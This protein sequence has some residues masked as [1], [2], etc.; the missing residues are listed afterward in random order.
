MAII[1]EHNNLISLGSDEVHIWQFSL[2]LTFMKIVELEHLLT[3]D[4]LARSHGLYG[5]LLRSRFIVG[6]GLLRRILQRYIDSKP[7]A[8]LFSY[9][10]SGKP[11]LTGHD[12]PIE[13]NL[14][15]SEGRA[16]LAIAQ[17]PVGID[18]EFV[19]VNL[20]IEGLATTVFT[21]EEIAD[22]LAVPE[23]ERYKYFFTMWVRKEA[24]MKATGHGLLESPTKFA[25]VTDAA[26]L[27]VRMTNSINADKTIPWRIYDL[28]AGLECVAA[29]AVAGT[30]SHRIMSFDLETYYFPS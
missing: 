13:F 2:D 23:Q 16:L 10:S 3:P 27:S 26:G 14:S 28:E 11:F 24:F 17:N 4:E 18:L 12:S 15:H 21:Q 5:Q 22:L 1:A 20:D 25:I 6:R 30:C 29:L 8:I 19:R 7:E 9:G